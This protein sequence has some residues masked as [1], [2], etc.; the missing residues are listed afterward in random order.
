MSYSNQYFTA[1]TY[2][3]AIAERHP[4]VW[5]SC[6][7]QGDTYESLV[8]D[9]NSPVAIPTQAVLDADILDLTRL[10]VW[11]AVKEKR[12][13]L[14][15]GGVYVGGYWFNSDPNSRIQQVSLRLLGAALP[16]GIMWKTLSNT[17]VE[18]TQQLAEDIFTA[19]VQWDMQIFAVA[20]NYRHQILASSDPTSIDISTGWPAGFGG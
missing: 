3:E 5:V 11:A 17:F 7:G 9:P 1:V 14:Q 4:N 18:M 12:D 6:L 15:A 16:S 19:S 10:K 2:I 20:E 13:E 8:Q